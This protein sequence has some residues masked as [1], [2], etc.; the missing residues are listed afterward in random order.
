MKP[1]LE[2]AWVAYD[3]DGRGVVVYADNE[4]Q[5]LTYAGNSEDIDGVDTIERYP[6][7]DR[8]RPG[9]VPTKIML[10]HGWC[11]ECW[12]CCHRVTQDGCDDC[13]PTSRGTSPRPVTTKT[14][15]FCS[16]HCYTAWKE[17]RV[18]DERERRAA[19]RSIRKIV[20]ERFPE[21]KIKEVFASYEKVP[22]RNFSGIARFS[23]PG[24]LGTAQYREVNLL[25]CYVENRDLEAWKKW[26]GKAD[27]V[28]GSEAPLD[29]HAQEVKS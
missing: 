20:R 1:E 25:E 3:G 11:F 22:G 26:Q 16:R 2:V 12:N 7:F 14:E 18:R 15:V 24:S 21:A 10:E 6:D 4:P 19:I 27:P 9:P 13:P 23:F 17:A 8:Y 28:F 5:A 29:S